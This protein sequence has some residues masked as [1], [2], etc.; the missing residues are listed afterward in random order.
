MRATS[1]DMADRANEPVKAGRNRRDVFARPVR[2][3]FHRIVESIYRASGRYLRRPERSISS[4]DLASILNKAVY[5][6]ACISRDMLRN[7]AARVD[8]DAPDKMSNGS[9][10]LETAPNPPLTKHCYAS[11]HSETV[12]GVSQ[13]S[14]YNHMLSIRKV[15]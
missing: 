10:P 6:H 12:L 7:I 11:V 15:G 14:V 13:L 9:L 8:C 1:N 2:R 3:I 5:A 4:F